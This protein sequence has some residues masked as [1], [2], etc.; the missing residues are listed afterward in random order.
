MVYAEYVYGR[1]IFYREAPFVRNDLFITVFCIF[2][3]QAISYT[4]V[5]VNRKMKGDSIMENSKFVTEWVLETVKEKYAD[6]IALVVSHSTL[7]IDENEE[8]ISYFVPITERGHTFA[9]TF[10]LNG[11]GFDIWGIEWGRLEKFAALEEY[12]ITCLAD[13][14]VLYAR[15]PADTLR[16]EQ[17]KKIQ[18]EHLA[19]E[20]FMRKRAL[21]AYAQAKSIYYETLFAKGS[22]VKLGAGYTL[23]YLARAIAF[24]NCSY[25]KKSQTD[26]LNELNDMKKIPDGFLKMY[27]D[28]ILEPSNGKQKKMCFELI[29]MVQEFLEKNKN[30][31]DAGAHT[32]PLEYNFQDMADWYAELSYTWLRIRHYSESGNIV[33]T[34]MWGIMLQEE[35]NRICTDFGFDKMELMDGFNADNLSA[36]AARADRLEEQIRKIIQRGGGVIR[37]YKNVKELISEV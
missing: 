24:T 11:E 14:E 28:I 4:V 1:S 10:I 35:L 19:D 31:S 8:V 34:Y 26:Q 29:M 33:K 27:R 20:A 25:F 37:E 15:T 23:D 6:D 30:I 32:K 3:Y 17:L 13:G 22:D 21:E 12:N 2:F 5:M 18:A 7:R 9:R 36:F 16:F